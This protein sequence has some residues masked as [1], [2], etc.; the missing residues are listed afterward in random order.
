MSKVVDRVSALI[1]PVLNDMGFE[2]VDVELT[3]E[4]GKFYLRVYI[5][6]DNHVTVDDCS[7]VSRVL[8]KI[9][10]DNGIQNHDF[11]EV[12]SPGVERA[13]KKDKDFE[14][15]QGHDVLVG[16][17]SNKYGKKKFEGKLVGRKDEVIIIDCDGEMLSFDQRDVS[18]I[19]T[20]FKF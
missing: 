10:D 12:S 19:K 20:I 16:L 1:E 2:L 4:G 15:Y 3:K 13:L 7:E 9:I 5:D 11:F 18:L 14:K 17:F 6:K 8:D